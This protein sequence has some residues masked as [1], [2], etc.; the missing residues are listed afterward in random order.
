M[1][2]RRLPISTVTRRQPPNSG[3][4]AAASSLVRLAATLLAA[5][6]LMQPTPL[7]AQ[8]NPTL[9]AAGRGLVSA[10]MPRMVRITGGRGTGYGFIVG[11]RDAPGGGSRLII[12][13]ADHLVRDPT[14][15]DPPAPVDI[16]FYGNLVLISKAE[17]LPQHLP[18]EQG[19]LAVLLSERPLT[20]SVPLVTMAS[21]P[22]LLPGSPAWEI[23]RPGSW[24][25]PANPGQFSIRL[26]SG[27]LL[28]DGLDAERGS[29]GGAVLSPQ[30]LVGMVVGEAAGPAAS[31][32]VLPIELIAAKLAEWELK[33]NIVSPAGA[34]TAKVAASGGLAALTFSG[35]DGARLPGAQLTNTMPATADTD[36][37]GV[38]GSR[39]PDQI[40]SLAART[41]NLGLVPL[42]ASETAARRSWVPADAK[43]SPMGN[44]S[45]PLMSSP[46]R[47]AAR[48]GL[49]PPGR[50]LPPD[51]WSLGAYQITDKI[52]GGAWFLASSNGRPLGYVSGDDMIEIWPAATTP[53]A[54][55]VVR[56]WVLPNPAAAPG[57]PGKEGPERHA[58]LRD[59]GTH[60]DLTL[61]VVCQIAY[62]DSV[63]L[64]TPPPPLAGAILPS[65]RVSPMNGSWGQKQAAELHVLLPRRVV[66]TKGTRLMSCI[67]Q[68]DD[69]TEQQIL[70]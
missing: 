16:S 61:P 3:I 5:A 29:A 63:G 23:G 67:G 30:G 51:V 13:T 69:C 28:F 56:D 66:E 57:S 10:F 64:Y 7:R 70:P 21:T 32:R 47:E 18:P 44:S 46:R 6:T 19:D 38:A 25:S 52:D 22:A 49:L 62:C 53:P 12:V 31:I 8:T 11:S 15:K 2:L 14:S 39:Q 41:A 45:S 54:G 50:I 27:W 20:A 42:L 65:F 68:G 9:L 1:A 60:Y 33:T 26:P 59:A 35:N 34:A 37:N 24:D 36:P 43:L 58:V 4:S 17:V 40:A 48:I 55:R